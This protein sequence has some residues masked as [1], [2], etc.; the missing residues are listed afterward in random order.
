MKK[1]FALGSV[2]LT[3]AMVCGAGEAMAQ[4]A[5]IDH[6]LAKQYFAEAKAISDRDNG[7]L[8]KV[9]LCGP[10]LFVDPDARQGVANQADQEGK[11]VAVDGVF[12][13]KVPEEVGVANTATT[14]AGVEWTM[15]MWPLPQYKSP[16]ARLMLHEC[17]HRVQ[18][19]IGLTPVDSMNGHLDSLDGRIWLQMEWRALEHALW[20]RGEERR[21]DVADAVYFRNF[22]R[23]LFPDTARRENALEMN[24]GMAEYTGVKLSTSSLEEFAVVAASS[25]RSAATRTQSYARSFAYSSGPAYGGLL[26]SVNPGW[27]KGLTPATDLGELLARGYKIEQPTISKTEALRRAERYDGGEVVT[28]ETRGEEKHQAQ[29]AAARKIFVDGPLL[30]LRVGKDFNY[31]FD[32]NAVLGVDENLTLYRGEVQV[33]DQWGVLRATEGALFRRENNRI[34]SVQVAAPSD[35]AKIPLAGK[36]W[37]L[38]LRPDWKLVP[39]GRTGDFAVRVQAKP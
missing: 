34:V 19:K 21:R 4:E 26:D 27:R 16:R 29:V 8:W 13:G 23:S 9:P 20:Q 12:A 31:T 2:A 11:L 38:E 15:V 10:L 35:P 3:V 24:E 7:A 33:S 14:W 32:P 18:K 25:L 39:E 22:R 1:V 28:I 5:A 30:L 17:F 36:G 6:G 37:T